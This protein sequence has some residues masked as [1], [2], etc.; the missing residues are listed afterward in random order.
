MP[1]NRSLCAHRMT[2]VAI[3]LAAC[4]VLSQGCATP[5]PLSPTEA[6]FAALEEED[7]RAAKTHFAEGLRIDPRDGRA[8]HGQARAQLAGRDPEGAL[9]SLSSLAK[10]DKPRFSGEARST[11]ANGLEDAARRRLKRDQFE[12]GLAAARALARLDPKRTGLAGLLGRALVGE[13]T[14]RRYQGEKEYALQL[15]RE[16]CRVTPGALEAWVGATEILLEE[17]KSKQAMQMLEAARK[18]H[19]T[20]GAIRS[21]TL[22]VLHQR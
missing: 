11:H 6:G 12:L 16:A 8:W 5:P 3:T 20:A 22:Q 15:Y 18:N 4:L 10:V 21:L 9:R 17:R 13:A 1:V 7:W 2:I 19:P 14:R